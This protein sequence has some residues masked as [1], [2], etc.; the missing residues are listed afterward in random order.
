M[1]LNEIG[2]IQHAEKARI[3]AGDSTDAESAML[4][5]GAALDL[6]K[7][8]DLRSRW[9]KSKRQA[10]KQKWTFSEIVRV[11]EKA[12]EPTLNLSSYDSL[13][14]SYGLSRHLIELALCWNPEHVMPLPDNR[15]FEGS[16]LTHPASTS[17]KTSGRSAAICSNDLA[18]PDGERRPCSHSCSV[19]TDTPSS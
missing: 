2:G 3:V 5:G 13:L 19:R 10:L 15:L 8:A 4:F 9:L 17:R 1:F 7:E 11:L 18:A 14:R 12:K 16:L 6:D